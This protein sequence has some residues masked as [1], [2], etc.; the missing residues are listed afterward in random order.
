MS[1]NSS[2]DIIG[3]RNSLDYLSVK[4]DDLNHMKNV[5]QEILSLVTNLQT[6]IMAKVKQIE[7]L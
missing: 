3:M 2:E 4:V 5:K 7:S 6:M 1:R